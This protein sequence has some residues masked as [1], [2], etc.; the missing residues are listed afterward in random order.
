[1]IKKTKHFK[2][3]LADLCKYSKASNDKQN[4]YELTTKE[5]VIFIYFFFWS[6]FVAVFCC[7]CVCFSFFHFLPFSPFIFSF[8]NLFL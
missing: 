8:T 3:S 1:M 4:A 7:V 6:F 5:N 2:Y